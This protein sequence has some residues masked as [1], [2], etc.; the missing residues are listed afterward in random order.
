ME[1]WLYFNTSLLDLKQKKF[2]QQKKMLFYIV[3]EK[4]K[5]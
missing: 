2:I 1:F 4:D 3:F 5:I